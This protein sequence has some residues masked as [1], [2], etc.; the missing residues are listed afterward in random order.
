VGGGRMARPG[1]WYRDLICAATW[2]AEVLSAPGLEVSRP[3][4]RVDGRHAAMHATTERKR[5]LD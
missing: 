3:W 2:D 5:M 4:E 1:F